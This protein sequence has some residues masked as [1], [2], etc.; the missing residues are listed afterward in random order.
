MG[1]KVSDPQRKFYS[2]NYCLKKV[3]E[4]SYLQSDIIPQS[5]FKKKKKKQTH[6]IAVDGRK[7]SN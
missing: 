3:E 7:L 6:Q 1:H 2:I 5:F 4:I